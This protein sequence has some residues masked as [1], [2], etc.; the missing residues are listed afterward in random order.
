MPVGT[1]APSPDGA[2]PGTVTDRRSASTKRCLR[3][4]G[5]PFAPTNNVSGGTM[6]LLE[7]WLLPLGHRS[8]PSAASPLRPW[9]PDEGH[10][11][12]RRPFFG[13]YQPIALLGEGSVAR[14]YLAVSRGPVG[15]GNLAR[16]QGD[17]ARAGRTA[18]VPGDVPARGAHGAGAAPP[19]HRADLRDLRG[20]RALRGGDGVP[21]RP[22][23]GR[24]A[25][26]GG[27][28]GHVAV[29]APVG[30]HPGAGRAAPRPRGARRR[31]QAAADRP[32]R[33]EPLQR[34]SDLRRTGQ[35]G[36]LR[37][38]QVRGH[39]RRHG[40]PA[41]PQRHRQARLRR[42]RAVRLAAHRS[43]QR[44][45]FGGG[46]A[47]GGAGRQ[48]AAHLREPHRHRRRPHR[49]ARSRPSAR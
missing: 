12:T 46:D 45:L 48:A 34:V 33:R 26:A 21:R 30:A 42:A 20:A 8:W 28:G 35:A 10:P 9:L 17:P 6:T 18:P 40:R 29:A 24:S 31:G 15:W 49:R 43:A 7:R 4:R 2:G 47:L 25:A 22:D 5:W 3:P 32:P 13:R 23:P 41:R 14:V 1:R 19:Q 36:R 37:H 27:P 16:H 44:R 11:Q 38:R 39:G